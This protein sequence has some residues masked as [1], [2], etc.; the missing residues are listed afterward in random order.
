MSAFLGF[1]HV[2]GGDTPS[3][4]V[5]AAFCVDQSQFEA[6]VGAALAAQGYRLAWAE[7][8][9]PAGQW[10]ARHPGAGG[11]ALARLVHAGRHVAFGPMTPLRGADTPWEEAQNWLHVQELG[12]ITPLD[13]QF[14]VH[15]KKS[16]PN[17]LQD[18]LFGQPEPSE[19]ERAAFGDAPLATYAVLDAAKM[20]YLLTGL[21]QSSGLRYQSLFQG[22]AQEELGEYAP[23]LVELKDGNDFTR[24][25][26]TGPKGIGGLWEKEL[27]IFIR[28][29]ADFD[30]LRR[31]LRKFTKVQDENGKWFYFRFWEGKYWLAIGLLSG[32]DWLT[33]WPLSILDVLA[34]TVF[35]VNGRAYEMD[36]TQEAA[37]PSPSPSVLTTRAIELVF[38]VAMRPGIAGVMMDLPP[39]HWIIPFLRGILK[40]NGLS[41]ELVR[42][43]CSLKRGSG[44]QFLCLRTIENGNIPP[45]VL[46]Q[47]LEHILNTGGGIG[48]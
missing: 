42:K 11:E 25:L 28:S 9:L 15:P 4:L 47:T 3:R 34:S 44:V 31:H 10:I 7:D 45:R 36:I 13:A 46:A 16:V 17:A 38:C 21:L 18:A 37:K 19:A 2:S 14:G 20:P 39:D 5:A 30:A 12:P 8:V 29:R 32:S 24:R 6:L 23:Y 1:C 22:E 43:L 35:V 27:G 40:S 48:M 26:F 41:D 33:G